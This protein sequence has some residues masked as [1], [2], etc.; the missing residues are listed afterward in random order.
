MPAFAADSG[1]IVV[2]SLKGEVRVTMNGAAREVRAGTVLE[3]PAQVRTGSDGAIELRQGATSV[4]VG[5]DTDLDF[6][7]LEK[8]GAPVDRIVQP[9]GNAFYDI[10]KREGRKLRVE[11]P[12]LVGVIKGT[13]FNV[14]SQ[15][16][17]TTISLFE[18]R[19]E[20]LSSDGNDVVDL[21]AGEIASRK[22]GDAGIDVARMNDKAPATAPR[23]QSESG[24]AVPT[25]PPGDEFVA[26][27]F[28]PSMDDAPPV[29][30]ETATSVL[31]DVTDG[32][33][34]EV[35]TPA[36]DIGAGADVGGGS[37]SVDTGV[38]VDPGT[39]VDAGTAVDMG[40]SVGIDAGGAGSI[41][42]G[43]DTALDV[44]GGGAVVDAGAGVDLSTGGVSAGVDAGIVVDAGAG[45]VDVGA[46]VDVETG[47]P[48]VD[49]GVSAGVNTG[50]GAVDVGV[51]VGG[52]DVD[53][54]VDL[55]LDDDDR[56]GNSGPGGGDDGNS[57][58]GNDDDGRDSS[59]PGNSGPGN[60][61]D[62]LL[63]D[64]LRRPGR[65]K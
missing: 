28:A 49:A 1:D 39:V 60:V 9:R 10:G 33:R 47:V 48:G 12:Y 5:P 44:G 3:L 8:R 41:D 55:G 2:A 46:T 54:G 22:R 50:A 53:L 36:A 31:V 35:E 52:I 40:T 56:G 25:S 23:P 51:S 6:P 20:V 34:G 58:H 19:L 18:G 42:A 4:N 61:V 13:Q 65:K 43:V 17:G 59:N 11:T 7:A 57:G 14:A 30:I 64:L 38:A 27:A 29:A 62:G 32:V 21:H 16:D 15:P 24:R 26:E 63:D 37:I 45:G